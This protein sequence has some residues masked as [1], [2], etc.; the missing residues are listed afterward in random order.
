MKPEHKGEL[1]TFGGAIIWS[2]FPIITILSYIELPSMIS[3]ALS[4]FFVSIFFLVIVIYKK[5]FSELKNPLL[6]KYIFWIVFSIGILY[7]VFYYFGL[8]KTTSGNAS[9]IALFEICTSFLFFN[10]IR[11]EPFS[12]ESKIGATLMVIGA[13]IVLAPNFSSLN[14]GDLFILIATFCAPIGNF[15]QQKATK[16][17]SIES[18]LFLR[19][20][21]AAP[22]ILLIAYIFGQHLVLQ[23]IKESFWFILLN[24]FIILGLSKAFWLEGIAR[25]SVTKA[26]ALNSIGPLFTL[27]FA[28]IIFHQIPTIWQSTSLFFFFFGVLFLTEN[29]KLKYNHGKSN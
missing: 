4:T 27:F 7:Y 20:I 12:L 8:T 17:F 14:L 22:L 11:K 16:T 5:K 29:L 21:V 26:N 19:S 3:L 18:I 2:F 6:W 9:I 24:G 10:L 1:F 25:I 15:F 28:F 23:Q 13:V